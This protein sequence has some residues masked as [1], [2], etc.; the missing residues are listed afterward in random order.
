MYAI[1]S[2]YVNSLHGI[3]G[4]NQAYLGQVTLINNQNGV[5]RLTSMKCQFVRI[6][7]AGMTVNDKKYKISRSNL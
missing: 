2:Y 5:K 7:N 1:R 4:W 3:E 6:I